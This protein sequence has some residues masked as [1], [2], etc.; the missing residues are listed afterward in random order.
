VKISIGING[1]KQFE[2]LNKRERFCIESLIKI[3]NKNKNIQLFNVCFN[4]EDIHYKEFITLNT[5]NK[6]SN[7]FIKDYFN[8]KNSERKQEINENTKELPSVKEIFDVLSNT[9]CD[10]FLFLNNDIILSDRFLKEIEPE[11]ECYPMSRVN[12]KDINSLN[13]QPE[14]IEYCVHGFDAFLV[15]KDAWLK[16]RNKFEDFIL[17]RFYWDTFFATMFNKVCE[18]KNLNKL[19]PICFHIDHPNVSAQKTIENYYSE[20]LFTSYP[21]I[22]NTWFNYVYNILFKRQSLNNC[23]WYYPHANEVEL[24]NYYLKNEN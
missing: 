10:Y 13:E 9:D 16:V 18:C 5:L 15:K 4:T 11:Y 23:M 6:K 12:I 21:N 7:I 8:D 14:I 2:S 24:E 1:F 22:N 19:P 17:G 20:Y 3:K